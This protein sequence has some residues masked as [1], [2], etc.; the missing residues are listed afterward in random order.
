MLTQL[1]CD[2]DTFRS[3]GISEGFTKL[4]DLPAD[5][6]EKFVADDTALMLF[7]FRFLMQ[8]LFG[9]ISIDLKMEAVVRDDWLHIWM[10]DHLFVQFDHK[11][12]SNQLGTE[13]R[14]LAQIEVLKAQTNYSLAA[15]IFNSCTVCPASAGYIPG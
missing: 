5:E 2:I 8:V 9:E 3:F 6:P 10:Q 13:R 12:N 1:V 7:G 15:Q 11:C 4:Y 14:V